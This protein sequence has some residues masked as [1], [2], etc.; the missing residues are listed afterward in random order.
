MGELGKVHL[1]ICCL[2]HLICEGLD[3]S[4]YKKDSLDQDTF[5]LDPFLEVLKEPFQ[6]S[7]V[8]TLRI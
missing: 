6:F 7:C 8:R 4:F 5:T 2:A 3:I 1:K